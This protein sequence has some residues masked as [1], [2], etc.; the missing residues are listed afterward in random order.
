MRPSKTNILISSFM[1][2]VFTVFNAGI[3]VVVSLCPMMS[4]ENSDC[5]MNHPAAKD[6]LSFTSE[7]PDCCTSH[8]VAERNTIPYLSVEKFKIL[9]QLPLDQ[10]ASV[11]NDIYS[12]YNQS[13]LTEVQYV[14]PSP[15]FSE[16]VSLSILNST[17]LI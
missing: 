6:V 13:S 7:I 17:L 5:E 16:T 11:T 3:P 4:M 15:P 10:I 14:S 8:I 2:L 12:A 9:P 1:I